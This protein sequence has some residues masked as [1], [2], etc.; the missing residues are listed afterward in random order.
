MTQYSTLYNKCLSKIEDPQLAMLPDEDLENV[1][2]GWMISAIAK[3]RKCTNDLSDRDEKLKQFTLDN[4]LML[5]EHVYGNYIIQTI[6]SYWSKEDLEEIVLKVE[7][8]FKELSNKKY[9]SNVIEK[10]LEKSECI[11]K[12]YIEELR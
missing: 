9:S 5:F 3:H 11:L 2:H 4:V 6:V 10:C 7:K 1:L 12:K 8:H